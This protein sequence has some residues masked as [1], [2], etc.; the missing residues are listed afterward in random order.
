MVLSDGYST[1][2]ILMYLCKLQAQ[3]A[4]RVRNNMDTKRATPRHIIIKKSKVKD[5]ERILKA[6][7]ESS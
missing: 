7:K 1:V 2:V 5:E 6:T 4:Q 3:E